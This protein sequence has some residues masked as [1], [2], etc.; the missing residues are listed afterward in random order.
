[1]IRCF[2]S[3]IHNRKFV[4]ECDQCQKT[5]YLVLEF[6]TDCNNWKTRFA[7][8]YHIIVLYLES[9]RSIKWNRGTWCTTIGTRTLAHDYSSHLWTILEQQRNSRKKSLTPNSS[10]AFFF[11]LSWKPLLHGWK[12]SNFIHNWPISESNS[13]GQQC[14]QP[15]FKSMN[16]SPQCWPSEIV[17]SVQTSNSS[18]TLP[19]ILHDFLKMRTRQS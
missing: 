18:W 4:G 14:I 9:T 11:F 3:D 13:I 17:I 1:M 8:Q 16:V 15:K 19:L 10:Y 12:T 6:V 5:I 2:V 7:L